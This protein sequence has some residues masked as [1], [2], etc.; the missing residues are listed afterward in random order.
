MT[1]IKKNKFALYIYLCIFDQQFNT[2]LP[3]IKDMQVVN[4]F[5]DSYEFDSIK[6]DLNITE[7]FIQMKLAKLHEYRAEYNAPVG[8]LWATITDEIGNETARYE[9]DYSKGLTE[10]K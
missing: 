1:K 6:T 9:F 10:I 2:G 7:S 4:F 5:E 3:K 8:Q